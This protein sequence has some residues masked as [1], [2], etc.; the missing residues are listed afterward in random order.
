MILRMAR[1]WPWSG[2]H[3]TVRY[4]IA[5]HQVLPP[6]CMADWLVDETAAAHDLLSWLAIRLTA[7]RR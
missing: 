4:R 5:Q 3:R 1:P 6:C 2:S 7:I